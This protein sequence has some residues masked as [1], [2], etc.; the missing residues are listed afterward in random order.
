MNIIS[1]FVML[2]QITLVEHWTQS[3]WSGGDGQ[4]FWQDS[5]SYY[6]KSSSIWDEV[7]NQIL[8]QNPDWKKIYNV[9]N[10]QR[11]YSLV[12][13]TDSII[14]AGTGDNPGP[15]YKSDDDGISWELVFTHEHWATTRPL[16]KRSDDYWYAGVYHTIDKIIITK[17]PVGS[18]YSYSKISNADLIYTLIE[19][20]G[21]LIAGT[22]NSS[23]NIYKEL[24][25]GSPWS[26]YASLSDNKVLCIIK[27]SDVLYASTGDNNGIVAKSEDN[28]NNW[29]E[30]TDLSGAK[31][32]YCLC[33]GGDSAI[34]AGTDT[35]GLIYK[36][37]N[38]GTTWIECGD[39][40]L[41]TKVRSLIWV[42]SKGMLV[43]GCE[44]MDDTARA[45]ISINNGESWISFGAIPGATTLY[46]LLYTYN[47]SLLA[48]TDCN[49]AI[50]KAIGF[51]SSGWLVSSVYNTGTDNKSVEYDTIRWNAD[52]NEQDI[53]VKVR[54]FQDTVTWSD[55]I[56]WDSCP[57][58]TNGQY[59]PL[60][61]SVCDSMQFIQYRLDFS[62]QNHFVS[63]GFYEIRINYSL[64]TLPPAIES[65]I[66]Y[67][68]EEFIPPDSIIPNDKVVI[69]FGESVA[70]I[71]I[72]TSNIDSILK[73]SNGQVWTDSFGSISSAVWDST[74]KILTITLGK[75]G[76]SKW[77]NAGDT[78]YPSIYQSDTISDKWGNLCSSP[79]VITGSFGPV[80]D[81]I[82]ASDG[83][84]SVEYIDNDDYVTFYFSKRTNKPKIDKNN[85]NSILQISGHSWLDG[86]G[87]LRGDSCIWDSLGFALTCSLKIDSLRPTIAIGD[88]VYPDSITI[89]DKFERGTLVSS[90]IIS[91]SFG[92]YGPV[93]D[94]ATAYEGWPGETGLGDGD[95]VYIVFN[96]II[97][98]I[99]WNSLDID[100]VLI[101]QANEDTHTWHPESLDCFIQQ[102]DQQDAQGISYTVL[103]MSFKKWIGI[104]E[105]NSQFT[106][107]NSQLESYPN[108][109]LNSTYIR[110]Q[111]SGKALTLKSKTKIQ[112]LEVKGEK[113]ENMVEVGDTIYPNSNVIT[114]LGGHKATK[115]VV[116]QG[117]LDKKLL[118]ANHKLRASNLKSQ[119]TCNL[120]PVTKPVS[121]RIYNPAGQLVRTLVDKQK[122]PGEYKVQWNG[123]NEQGK[124]VKSGI[125]F[126]KLNVDG[127]ILTRKLTLLK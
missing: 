77:V 121:L 46:C 12:Q 103:Y 31:S 52:Y 124:K 126:Y 39:L 122:A 7:S 59:L 125:Y 92:E 104:E 123:L 111:V 88:T 93:M 42:E 98:T 117:G 75:D 72:D 116:L 38:T 70:P 74:Y 5:T 108:P 57:P 36:T 48:G 1:I 84:D 65:A 49:G 19:F 94:F 4:L 105:H 8:L 14:Y 21:Y 69:L 87:E 76:W 79:Y 99:T 67:G 60:L 102:F 95:Y 63:P 64:D 53:I 2:F 100:T 17:D 16:L 9:P 35:S 55:T 68:D 120:Q 37:L 43:A 27:V 58:C 32:V 96:K 44:C 51:D 3:D 115:S 81:S 26:S 25:V 15:L 33:Q 23:A 101:V 89:L 20:E 47:G 18:A 110:Y 28:G 90:C 107:Y 13:S 22:G 62:T 85:V 61:S 114:D 112:K 34:Y 119:V 82:I 40:P 24:S 106:I 54:S 86:F 113:L 83:A 78:I 45:F 73:L 11:V 30:C 109:F 56:P 80:I 50:F 127:H 6:A 41:A 97:D 66:A 91:G 10:A 118:F 29:I 71:S